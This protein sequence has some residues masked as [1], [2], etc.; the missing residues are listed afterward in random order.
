MT[1]LISNSQSIVSLSGYVRHQGMPVQG[2]EVNLYS[3]VKSS[4]YNAFTQPLA[5]IR[6]TSKGQFSFKVEPGNY[7]LEAIP[8]DQGRF[9][10]SR[11]SDLKVPSLTPIN[12]NINTGVILRGRVV[13]KG[14]D[15]LKTVKIHAFGIEPSSYWA[16]SLLDNEG[17]YSLILPRG[18][19][20]LL[21][22]DTQEG[23]TD[24]TFRF[25]SKKVYV[26][27]LDQDKEFDF[28]LGQLFKFDAN[29]F[30]ATVNAV[31]QSKVFIKANTEIEKKP[32]P[33]A[34]QE[35]ELTTKLVANKDGK[36]QIFLDRGAFDFII[37]PPLGSPYFG[38]EER[39][40]AVE[41]ST[42][43]SFNLVEGKKVEGLIQF[44]NNKLSDCLIRLQEV[45]NNREYLVKSDQEGRFSLLLP[46]GKYK[47]AVTA[48]PKDAQTLE[49]DGS[50]HSSIAPWTEIIKVEGPSDVS[51][52]LKKGRALKGQVKDDTGQPRPGVKI[53]VHTKSDMKRAL[54][55]TMTDSAGKFCIFLAP[56]QYKIVV[57]D[58]KANA[59][60]V[61]I[62]E[63][64]DISDLELIW[65][66]WCQAR[67]RV[68]AEDG[69]SIVRCQIKYLPYGYKDEA[70]ASLGPQDPSPSD[71]SY[72]PLGYVLTNEEGIG[73]ITVPAGIYSVFFHPPEAG[74]YL[75]KQLRQIS[76]SGDL[77]RK[78]ALSRK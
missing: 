44:E 62:T 74:S 51:I 21:A 40:V 73:Q 30:D 78:V 42:K 46:P 35:L 57:Q 71:L 15:Q 48:H 59:I 4:E 50:F 56:D 27:E 18:K 70:D 31:P 36:F 58:D 28:T 65:H 76:I 10:K 67:F 53:S 52:N 69:T 66:G 55:D 14:G 61:E 34:K 25:L 8:D 54:C 60:D 38:I 26:V 33:I 43:Q 2:V 24:N 5:T 29:V 11:V 1:T 32:F 16:S 12:M 47:L 41:E 77:E 13:T 63:Q 37:D 6:T 64:K 45:T 19:F 68:Q 9:L 22:L 75:P 20:H 17:Y 3:Q 72:M 49:I 7:C 39:G 23:E